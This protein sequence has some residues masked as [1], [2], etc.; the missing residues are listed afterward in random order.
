MGEEKRKYLRFE[1]FLPAELV[2]L[3]GKSNIS[4]RIIAHDFSR[5]GLKLSINFNLTQGSNMELK[6][7]LPEKRLSTSV[8][9][10]IIWIRS[11]DNKLEAGLKIK[12]MDKELKS[13]I[14]NWI[15]PKWIEKERG[16]KEKRKKAVKIKLMKS[17]PSKENSS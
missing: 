14:L 10:E 17:N 9:G 13:E 16:K 15:F 2:K 8:S 5:E 4:K 12:E 7:Y 6:L 11:V 3:D 1:C